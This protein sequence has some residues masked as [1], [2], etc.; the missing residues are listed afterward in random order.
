MN[1]LPYQET[2]RLPKGFSAFI[3]T[4]SLG[5]FNDNLFKMLIQLY[6]LIIIFA[7]N[8]ENIISHAAFVFT[9]PF[10]IF[11][12]WSGYLADRFSKSH[13][14]KII[15]AIEMGIM[16][17]GVLAFY[18]K[19]VNFMLFA[20]FLMAS[21]SAFFS[22]NKYGLIP[23][24]CHNELISKA[25]GILGMA[26]FFSIIL[27]TAFGGI[28]L[29]LTRSATVAS[30]FCIVFALLGFLTSQGITNTKP[31]GSTET[32]NKNFISKITENI[33]YLK[34]K[35]GL[36]LASLAGSY[37]WMLGL[38]FQTNILVYGTK[39]LRLTQDQ[40][41][42]LALLPAIMGI[43]IA[44]GSLLAGRLS[45]DKIEIGLV[46]LGGF[47]LS[48]AGILLFFSISSYLFTAGV[49]F[50]AGVFGGLFIIPLNAYIQFYAG[51]KEKGRIIATAGVLNGLFLV[52]GA[53][54]YRALAVSLHLSPAVICLIM[55][56]L[57][58]LVT[59]CICRVT[60]EYLTRL[61]AYFRSAG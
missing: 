52:L 38:V 14:I 19:S 42:E 10:V 54:L 20:L 35:R 5:A 17:L 7:P 50:F 33:L 44:M 11:G 40:S 58:I 30:L 43:G 32:F 49:L 23:E 55:G 18:L 39:H 47:G 3:A 51:E 37:F 41:F 9:I 4:Q 34:T 21:Q 6:V 28:L 27:G 60:P 2:M 56:L 16:L 13:L 48:I 59:I 12:P 53:I 57:T 1:I 31:S 15:K 25:N 36:F 26:T 46:P 45:K 29:T 22:P 8:A 24:T 61:Q